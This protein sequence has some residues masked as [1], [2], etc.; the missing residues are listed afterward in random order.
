MSVVDD[1]TLALGGYNLSTRRV[2]VIGSMGV[3][4]FVVLPADCNARMGFCHLLL[5]VMR[6]VPC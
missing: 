6:I 5:R 1:F 3:L 2:S 4:H